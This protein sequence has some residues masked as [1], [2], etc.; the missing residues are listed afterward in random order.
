[1][2]SIQ[3][4]TQAETRGIA[5]L[6][7]QVSKSLFEETLSSE[8]QHS[9]PVAVQMKIAGKEVRLKVSELSPDLRHEVGRLNDAAEK[10]EAMFLGDLI[11]QMHKAMPKGAFSGP[12]AD[13]ANDIFRQAVAEDMSRGKGIGV[14]D[15]LFRQLAE[16]ALREHIAA[17]STDSTKTE[18]QP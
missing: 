4:A 14:A 16:R 10:V 3:S 6:V 2:T 9:D 18:N 8:L 11:G 15:Q 5:R 17:T 1:M 13:L 7:R 12:M